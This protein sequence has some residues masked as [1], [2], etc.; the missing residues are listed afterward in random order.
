MS[1]QNTGVSGLIIKGNLIKG[2]KPEAP[3]EEGP[4]GHTTH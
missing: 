1:E 4:F 2:R 3:C